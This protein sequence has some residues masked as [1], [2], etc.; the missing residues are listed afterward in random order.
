MLKGSNESLGVQL[1][2]HHNL[3]HTMNLMKDIRNAIS[4]GT[5]KEFFH[6]FVQVIFPDT[7]N[8]NYSVLLEQY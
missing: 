5:Y 3:S 1:M 7:N 4:H 8:E 2:T 6:N